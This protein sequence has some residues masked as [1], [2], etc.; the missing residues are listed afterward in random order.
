KSPAKL[1][2][3]PSP[4]V[5]PPDP[6]PSNFALLLP[7]GPQSL[8]RQS[9]RAVSTAIAKLSFASHP[10]PTHFNTPSSILNFESGCTTTTTLSFV[11]NR[12]LISD[13]VGRAK[14]IRTCCIRTPAHRSKTQ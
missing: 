3:L 4:A 2:N 14:S 11:T 13:I 6:T 7:K 12:K 5:T 10:S 8:Y 1:T 9:P